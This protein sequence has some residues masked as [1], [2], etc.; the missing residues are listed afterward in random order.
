LAGI[1]PGIQSVM[2]S[3][4]GYFPVRTAARDGEQTVQAEYAWVNFIPSRAS[5]SIWGVS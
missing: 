1:W 3:L 5:R 2:C 4:A